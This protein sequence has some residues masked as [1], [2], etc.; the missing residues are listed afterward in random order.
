MSN[1]GLVVSISD[2]GANS[3]SFN[4]LCPDI[5]V[6]GKTKEILAHHD[7]SLTCLDLGRDEPDQLVSGS[8]P[9]RSGPVPAGDSI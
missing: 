1:G 6:G 2:S 4:G 8:G 9:I 7:C 3:Y 5:L